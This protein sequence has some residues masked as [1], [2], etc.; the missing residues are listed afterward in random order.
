MPDLALM[1]DNVDVPVVGLVL[2]YSKQAE[3]GR[4]NSFIGRI[5]RL[6]Q[7]GDDG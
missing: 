2:V 7:V 4:Q 3:Y 5:S 6:L 1:A